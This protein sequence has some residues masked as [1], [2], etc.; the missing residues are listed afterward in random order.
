MAIYIC[1]ECGGNLT[2]TG[3]HS[4]VPTRKGFTD[5]VVCTGCGK[6]FTIHTDMY[7]R[8]ICRRETR[9][10]KPPSSTQERIRIPATLCWK[11]QKSCGG[12]NGCS[13]F[14]GFKPVPGWDAIR[15]D[16]IYRNSGPKLSYTVISCPEFVAGRKKAGA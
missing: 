7:A 13:W 2:H 3:G 4:M 12:P 8:E 9:Q 5:H 1:E 15:N 10:R 6:K 14:N 16:T 11:C